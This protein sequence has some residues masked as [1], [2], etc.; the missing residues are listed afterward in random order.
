VAHQRPDSRWGAEAES[1]IYEAGTHQRADDAFFVQ[2]DE[3]TARAVFEEIGDWIWQSRF[4]PLMRRG[5]EF[6]VWLGDVKELFS[7]SSDFSII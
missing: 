7:S 5:Q 2:P 4:E 1:W 6:R 3:A